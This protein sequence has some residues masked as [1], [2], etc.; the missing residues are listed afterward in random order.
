MIPQ[1]TLS[2]ERESDRPV[3]PTGMRPEHQYPM[4]TF[5]HGEGLLRSGL[6]QC[7]LSQA[8]WSLPARRDRERFRVRRS[9][10][11]TASGG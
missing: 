7:S 9:V 5:S 4:K 2:D 10:V 1:T 11:R 3:Y 6:V 8:D